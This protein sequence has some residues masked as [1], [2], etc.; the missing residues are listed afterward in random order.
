MTRK[1]ALPVLVATLVLG[2]GPAVADQ[3]GSSEQRTET[4]SCSAKADPHYSAP[5]GNDCKGKNKKTYQ[6]TYYSNDVKCGEKNAV[7][8]AGPTGVRVYASGDPTKQN[9]NVGTCSDGSGAAPA[10]VQG[11]ASAGGSPATGPRVVVDGDKD[12]GNETSQG[13]LVVEGTS[14]RC[15]HSYS[16]G[17]KADSDAPE[18]KDS[19]EDCG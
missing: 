2:I 15:G 10:P 8:P 7:T 19:S 13:Y 12:N 16:D 18:D 1:I 5:K 9:G 11:R 6:A 4:R 17:G 3:N 14:Y